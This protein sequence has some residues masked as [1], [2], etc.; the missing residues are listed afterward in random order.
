MLSALAKLAEKRKIDIGHIT[1]ELEEF[2]KAE[3]VVRGKL[4]VYLAK[5]DAG[6]NYYQLLDKTTL[7]M[8]IGRMKKEGETDGKIM[9]ELEKKYGKQIAG[10][11]KEP[12]LLLKLAEMRHATTGEK[13][14]DAITSLS[15]AIRNLTLSADEQK[16]LRDALG[17]LS[18]EYG[19]RKK[20]TEKEMAKIAEKL[21]A[22]D[23]LRGVVDGKVFGEFNKQE[24]AM[25]GWLLENKGKN[26]ENLLDKYEG[27]AKSFND[28]LEKMY[29]NKELYR[30]D[31][32]LDLEKI[33]REGCAFGR[34]PLELVIEKALRESILERATKNGVADPK[35]L[36]DGIIDFMKRNSRDSTLRNMDVLEQ[37]FKKKAQGEAYTPEFKLLMDRFN[38][39]KL[40]PESLFKGAM[41]NIN[42]FARIWSERNYAMTH[43]ISGGE[44]AAR[45]MSN[46]AFAANEVNKQ[47]KAQM[48]YLGGEKEQYRRELGMSDYRQSGLES[49]IYETRGWEKVFGFIVSERFGGTSRGEQVLHM[50]KAAREDYI[51]TLNRY[52]ALYRNLVHPDSIFHDK[53][54]ASEEKGK[55]AWG[56][57]AYEEL[58]KRGYRWGDKKNGLELLMSVDRKSTPMIEYDEN[59][60]KKQG[61]DVIVKKGEIRDYAP[62]LARTMGS[63]YSTR[64]VGFVVLVKKD[65]KWVYGDP[66]LAKDALGKSVQEMVAAADRKV[67]M[68]Q[69][70]MMEMADSGA[71]RVISTKDFVTYAKDKNYEHFFGKYNAMDRAR[72]T[73]RS[74]FYKPAMLWGELIYGAYSD[75]LDNM[76]KWYA[77]QWQ[78]RQTLDRLKHTINEEGD[79]MMGGR[80]HD[81]FKYDEKWVDRLYD[82]ETVTATGR[83]I[84]IA[85]TDEDTKKRLKEEMEKLAK[86]EGTFSDGAK[87]WWHKWHGSIASSIAGEIGKAE[88]DYFNGRLEMRALDKLVH[89]GD[90]SQAAYEKLHGQMAARNEELRSE[91]K[92]AKEDYM[93]LNRDLIGWV[94]SQGMFAYAP[95]RTIWNL[96]IAGK[97]LDSHHVQGTVDAFY[98]ITESS[99]MRDPRV[100]IGASAPGWEHS[101]YVGY[102]TG[103]NVYERA[104]FWQTNSLWEQQMRLST[105]VVYAVHKWWNDRMS[106]FARYTSGYPATV[107]SDMMYAP[108]YEARKT[109][110]YF[111]ALLIVMPFQSRTYSDYFRARWQDAISFSGV[112]S[113]LATY[114]SLG[115]AERYDTGEDGEKRSWLKRQI[116]KYGMESS[117]Y[118]DTPFRIARQQR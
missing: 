67:T 61:F 10:L 17:Q 20:L 100:A 36:A 107:K 83:K 102:H 78:V 47:L 81:R 7:T 12:E 50:L 66:D 30:K 40:T 52:E 32:Q 4:M 111:K 2:R 114:Q 39:L 64:E 59:V 18:A 14:K 106:F 41:I 112:G 46:Y 97:A 108:Q 63:Y 6:K 70:K 92:K 93:G 60:L 28:R 77:A 103:Q 42:D 45:Y 80:A 26:Y 16:L 19:G 9:S 22:M 115:S 90:I 79:G 24:R 86:G 3:D 99:V 51:H 116:D 49:R 65:G 87:A 48:A 37:I 91:Y 44:N 73:L 82:S 1:R 55:G 31:G 105:D 88:S 98:Q 113:M 23:K 8:E 5:G 33:A 58:L 21:D 25:N 109:K 11:V 71:I 84:A 69:E 94:G 85:G 101:Y 104:R 27:I 95:Q 118:F 117:H 110:D 62:L 53:K 96:G 72:E 15:D 76:T 75:R 68:R 89:K 43:I 13:L 38:D 54:W 34:N 57:D 56:L 35:G 74:S 29:Q